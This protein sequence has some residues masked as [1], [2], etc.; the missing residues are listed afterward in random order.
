MIPEVTPPAVTL[1]QLGLLHQTRHRQS[2]GTWKE[3]M[4]VPGDAQNM[5]YLRN[6][7]VGLAIFV[8]MM[9]PTGKWH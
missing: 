9:N 7:L 3:L 8:F 1:A 6:Y 4:R 2:E 5:L